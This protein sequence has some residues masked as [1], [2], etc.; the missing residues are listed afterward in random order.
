MS[1][2]YKLQVF[3]DT[4]NAM[5]ITYP[6]PPSSHNGPHHHHWC[7]CRIVADF[8]KAECY[9]TKGDAIR[10]ATPDSE[11]VAVCKYM[12]EFMKKIKIRNQMIN[13]VFIDVRN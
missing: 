9:K 7:N 2:F 3:R 1:E 5:F 12:P 10:A 4:I 13:E 8:V 6:K 11:L